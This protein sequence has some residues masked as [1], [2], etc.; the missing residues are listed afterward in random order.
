MQ[1]NPTPTLCRDATMP[2]CH[3]DAMT[4]GRY[5]AANR[6]I[7]RLNLSPTLIIHAVFKENA[8]CNHPLLSN[9]YLSDKSMDAQGTTERIR[10]S[11][12]NLLGDSVHSLAGELQADLQELLGHIPFPVLQFL[13]ILLVQHPSDTVG[14]CDRRRRSV[15]AGEE[16]EFATR[17]TGKD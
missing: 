6:C 9:M 8:E 3:K 13:P 15:R 5:A 17:G 12:A 7:N 16:W 11:L 10:E 4:L 1:N 2:L 14:V